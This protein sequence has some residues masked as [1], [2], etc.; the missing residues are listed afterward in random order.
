MIQHSLNLITTVFQ[1]SDHVNHLST[2][3]HGY[4]LLN[5]TEPGSGE[6]HGSFFHR[7]TSHAQFE[8]NYL[9]PTQVLYT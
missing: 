8:F 3:C 1:D 2:I 7:N 9:M 5:E 6:Y 4:E